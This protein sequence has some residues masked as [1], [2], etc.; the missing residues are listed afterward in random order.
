M[1][2]SIIVPTYNEINHIENLINSINNLDIDEKEI[3]IVDGGSN[4]GTV[5]KLIELKEKYHNLYIVDNPDKYVSHGFNKAYSLTKGEYISLVGAHA[6]YPKNYFTK[7]IAEIELN[8]CDTAGGI[9][10]QTGIGLTGKAIAFA[11]SLK[12]GVGNTAFRTQ[13]KRMYV[14]SVAFAVY[15]RSIFEKVGLLDQDLIRNQDDEFHYRINA[16]G[17]K[18]LM[19]PELEVIYYVRESLW[20]LFSQY[21]QYG[22]YKP[23]VLKKVSSAIKLRHVIPSFYIFYLFSLPICFK[24]IFWMIPLFCYIISVLYFS[25]KTNTSA[26]IRLYMLTVFPVLHI[27]YG[28]G[29]ILGLKLI[30]KKY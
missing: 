6:F 1:K 22:F 16:S 7:C 28:L 4:D 27:A 17:F 26:I 13:K 8:S 23:L 25:F 5:K 21:F 30:F 20:K 24:Y 19:L 10:K 15:K 14:D 29:F 18:I 9:L 3:F 2:L 11:M 12:F